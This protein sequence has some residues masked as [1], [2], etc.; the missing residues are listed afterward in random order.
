MISTITTIVKYQGFSSMML[1][2]SGRMPPVAESRPLP[3]PGRSSGLIPRTPS[4]RFT[5]EKSM[6]GG[7]A[8]RPVGA[9][10]WSAFRK[11][12]GMISPKPSVTIA[13]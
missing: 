4:V 7:V 13:R 12:S 3:K 9:G 1:K 10:S 5:V 6:N 2:R 11:T 8:C